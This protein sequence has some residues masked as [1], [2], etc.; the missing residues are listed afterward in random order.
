MLR[1]FEFT[2]RACREL[3]IPLEVAL[4][5]LTTYYQETNEPSDARES[6]VKLDKNADGLETDLVHL[7][8]ILTFEF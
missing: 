8:Q 5:F 7:E 1:K 4:A 6:Q 2:R 3:F